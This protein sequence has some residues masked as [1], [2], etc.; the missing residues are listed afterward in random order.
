M[1][2]ALHVLRDQVITSLGVTRTELME[3]GGRLVGSS[4]TPSQREHMRNMHE[5][6]VARVDHLRSLIR[7]SV[8]LKRQKLLQYQ[9]EAQ[10]MLESLRQ[11]MAQTKTV[12]TLA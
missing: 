4:L 7:H 9:Q 6:A 11:S 12:G 10:K 5:H 1:T 8:H 3:L 2:D